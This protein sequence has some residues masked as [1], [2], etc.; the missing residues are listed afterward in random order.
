MMKKLIIGLSSFLILF[1]IL[2]VGNLSESTALDNKGLVKGNNDLSSSLGLADP[3]ELD[4]VGYRDMV[5]ISEGRFVQQDPMS[6]VRFTHEISG[7]EM[8]KYEITYELWYTVYHWAINNG[9]EFRNAGMEGSVTGGGRYPDYKNIGLAPTKYR[10]EP[11][12]MISWR[13][14][15]VWCNAYSQL[16]G[17]SPVY[18]N[19]SRK[20]LRNSNDIA[21]C[22]RAIMS[23][24]S[25]GY[26]LPT[27][28]EWE[29]AAR[30][31]GKLPY[32]YA[33]GASD[34]F[35]NDNACDEVAWYARNSGKSKFDHRSMRAHKV[36]EKKPNSLGIFDMS[37]NVWEWCWDWA[38]NYPDSSQINYEGA[39]MGTSRIARGGG[40]FNGDVDEDGNFYLQSGARNLNG[41][42]SINVG[43][44]FRVA[45]IDF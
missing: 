26:R 2:F 18:Y 30:E 43:I 34:S 3:E 11:V 16:C 14:A 31:L 17:F 20:V 5:S 9:Y 40:W 27:E 37:G 15:V 42:G 35:E 33:S 41:A 38:G 22:D 24:T 29:Y 32:N 39:L 28:G 36:G 44:G 25:N 6:G 4:G 21:S 13:D 45:R 8:G 19:Q 10:H 1:S 7:F 12:T 23:T